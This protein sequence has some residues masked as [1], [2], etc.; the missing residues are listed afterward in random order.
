[1]ELDGAVDVVDGFGASVVVGLVDDLDVVVGLADEV[2]AVS[3]TH[4]DVYKRQV[5]VIPWSKLSGTL[6]V[7]SERP[8]ASVYG[9]R[10][11]AYTLGETDFLVISSSGENTI[12]F[13]RD[14][15]KILSIVDD[16]YWERHQL[17][18]SSIQ[19]IDGD[20][21]PDLLLAGP[22]YGLNETGIAIIIDGRE[23][24]RCV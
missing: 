19:D 12:Y 13:Y 18:V 21:I 22:H 3:Y 6:Q 10:V 17:A 4:L 8:V 23:L 24:V 1:M 7:L 14:G 16:H 9:N 20:G 11:H 2:V 15:V 5:Y